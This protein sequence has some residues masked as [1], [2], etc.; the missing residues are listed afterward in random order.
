M[1]GKVFD[2]AMLSV[3]PTQTNNKREPT[4]FSSFESEFLPFLF[5][6]LNNVDSCYNEGIYNRHIAK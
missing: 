3:Q 2:A 1:Y 6:T 4:M 5:N